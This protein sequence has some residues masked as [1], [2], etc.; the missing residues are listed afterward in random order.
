MKMF[1]FS[2]FAAVFL[3]GLAGISLTLIGSAGDPIEQLKDSLLESAEL[4]Q[5]LHYLCDDIGGRVTGSAACERSVD[6]TAERFRA[7]GVDSVDSEIFEMPAV[8]EELSAS[9]QAVGPVQFPVRVTAMAYSAPTPEGGIT[10]PVIDIGEGTEADFRKVGDRARGSILI[11]RSEI[12]DSLDKLFQS[13]IR[14]PYIMTLAEAAGAAAIVEVS[15]RSRHLLYRHMASFGRPVSLPMAVVSR[16]DSMRLLRLLEDGAGVELNLQL[17]NRWSGPFEARNVVAEIR[18]SE[19]P[20]EIVLLGAHL[21]S[22]GMGTGALDN[23]CNVSM[24]IDVA[25][26]IAELDRPPRR[27][28]RFALFTGEEQGLWG[29]KGYVAAHRDEMD[30]HVAAVIVDLGSGRINGFSLGGRADLKAAVE[31]A[32]V[33]V[34]SWDV[35]GH[36]TDAFVGTDNFDFLLE[37]VPNL[38]ANQ[39]PTSYLPEYHAESDTVDKVDQEALLRNSAIVGLLVYGLAERD[40]RVGPRQSREEIS[41]LLETTGVDGQMKTFGIWEEWETGSRGR[42]D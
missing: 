11:L 42:T 3:V 18:G 28:V 17:E 26:R 35:G 29:S 2:A 4:I 41:T 12:L 14:L 25:R 8:W 38:V 33:P 20:D 5:D 39:D 15:T 40:A 37:G 9:A 21:D 13:Y 6:W 34:E 32:L 10:A 16:E 36:T 27:T 7:A 1:R 23:G 19:R 22:W 30:R 24:V 31:E